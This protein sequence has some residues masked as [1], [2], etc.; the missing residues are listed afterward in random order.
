MLESANLMGGLGGRKNA[1]QK[2]TYNVVSHQVVLRTA[3]FDESTG[4]QSMHSLIG[5]TNK[6]GVT[7]LSHICA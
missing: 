5:R 2:S 3:Y 7:Q 6:P 1:V 4:G